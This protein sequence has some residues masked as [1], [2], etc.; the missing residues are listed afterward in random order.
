MSASPITLDEL[1]AV[2]TRLTDLM[3]RE[4]AILRSMRPGDIRELQTD[5][6]E[7]T[8]SYE[9]MMLAVQKDPAVLTT[10]A[11]S[12]REA[13]R[14]ATARFN[15]VLGDNERTLRA[16]KSVSERLMKTI[17]AAATEQTSA[18]AYSSAGL[19]NS[20]STAPNRRTVAVTLNKQL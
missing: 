3:T 4:N 14:S 10:A 19:M 17:V 7:L 16:V 12:I 13:L 15:A 9:R 8:Q 11:P 1:L 20:G 5:K 2:T 6:V 18:P